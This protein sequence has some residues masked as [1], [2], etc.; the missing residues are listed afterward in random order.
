MNF[1]YSIRIIV[2]KLIQYI[3][4]II[5]GWQP[6]QD[7]R[8]TSINVLSPFPGLAVPT[9]NLLVVRLDPVQ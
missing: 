5:P 1:L 2:S 7:S 9:E 6:P 3:F 4:G 8:Q